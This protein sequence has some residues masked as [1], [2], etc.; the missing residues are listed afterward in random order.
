MP[1]ISPSNTKT[2]QL[3]ELFA[4]W[5]TEFTFSEN[6]FYTDGVINETEYEHSKKKL[7]FIAKEPNA[8]NHQ[9]EIDRSFVTEWNETRPDYNFACRIAEWA[10]GILND[11]PTYDDKPED[12]QV[13]LKNIAFMN[14]KK[15]GGKGSI[16]IYKDFLEIIKNQKDFIQREI[17]IIDPDIIILSLSQDKHVRNI[18]FPGINWKPSGYTNKIAKWR[19]KKIIDFYHPSSR[20]VGAAAY[21]LLQNIINGDAFKNL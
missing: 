13:Q 14:V 8:S 15:S 5:K 11:F 19:N 9:K 18:L 2:N 10:Y 3:N 4:K 12:I 7:L 17:E 21:S 16:E 20:N 6:D 1:E